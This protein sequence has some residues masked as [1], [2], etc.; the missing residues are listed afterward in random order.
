MNDTEKETRI[1]RL[2]YRANH[3]GIK[4]MDIILGGFA[5]AKLNLLDD[6]HIDQFETLMSQRNF[7]DFIHYLMLT[8]QADAGKQLDSIFNRNIFLRSLIL[9]ESILNKIE[10]ITMQLDIESAKSC[11]LF[12]N[13]PSKLIPS[14]KLITDALVPIIEE[15]VGFSKPVQDQMLVEKH[16]FMLN[17]IQKSKEVLNRL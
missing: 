15:C 16:P 11:D 2:I 9:K 4:E 6:A 14:M 10:D 1:K 12:P 7:T 17:I 3:R 8:Q 5:N 13:I